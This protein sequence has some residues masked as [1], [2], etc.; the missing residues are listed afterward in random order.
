MFLYEFRL[1]FDYAKSLFIRL[2]QLNINFICSYE[3]SVQ[4]EHMEDRNVSWLIAVL[5]KCRTLLVY[6]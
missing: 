4:K 2:K 5:I 6:I 3:C 1:R